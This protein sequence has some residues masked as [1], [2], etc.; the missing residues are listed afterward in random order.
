MKCQRVLTLCAK[1]CLTFIKSPRLREKVWVALLPRI[2][3]KVRWLWLKIHKYVVT[4]KKR[5]EA[6]NGSNQCLS[7]LHILPP[8]PPPR[9][10]IVDHLNSQAGCMLPQYR[11]VFHRFFN[12]DA[13]HLI[14]DKLSNSTPSSWKNL[15]SSFFELHACF[16]SLYT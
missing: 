4:L 7:S 16:L 3:K 10:S 14:W 8:K 9:A 15:C 2:L 1:R 6:Q 11:Y 12:W 13:L 5:W